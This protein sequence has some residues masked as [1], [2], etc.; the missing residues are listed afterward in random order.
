MT[1]AREEM[2]FSSPGWWSARS[3]D[4]KT[5]GRRPT[6][7]CVCDAA[8][9]FS[10]KF[11]NYWCAR[12]QLHPRSAR[13]GNRSRPSASQTSNDPT[14]RALALPTASSS[15]QAIIDG[16]G[17]LAVTD[18]LKA[19]DGILATD[20]PLREEGVI[21]TPNAT[22]IPE[23]PVIHDG[24]IV[25][26]QDGRWGPQEYSRWLQMYDRKVIHHMCIPTLQSVVEADAM[27]LWDKIRVWKWEVD[28]TCS[29]PELGFLVEDKLKAL[30]ETALRVTHRF[31]HKLGD[32]VSEK[33]KVGMQLLL[34]LAQ[35]LDRLHLLLTSCN[36]VIALSAHV[37]HL[38]L[39]LWRYVNYYSVVVGHLETLTLHGSVNWD[40]LPVRG[41]FTND[42]S[43]A[44]SMFRVGV[45]FWFI[46]MK[47]DKTRIKKWAFPVPISNKLSLEMSWPHLL[48]NETD[49]TGI[50]NCPGDWPLRMLH[51]ATN[52][53]CD[54]CLPP[55]EGTSES[56]SAEQPSQK[57]QKDDKQL[58]V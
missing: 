21:T 38:T 16:E 31:K 50:L 25:T 41:A 8:I 47:T 26:R 2:L 44:Q 10:R 6:E 51:E 53:I 52:A 58:S 12:L 4:L 45:P 43:V 27:V 22:Y 3:Q 32:M 30:T 46:Q 48:R 1:A 49:L 19:F 57:K 37:Q 17:E 34:M 54:A 14:S 13:G 5:S 42:A 40:V 55:L 36:H 7:R 9:P 39:E 11:L 33:N 35:C 24:Q 28:T 18:E 29:M 20:F 23:F 56:S 15:Q